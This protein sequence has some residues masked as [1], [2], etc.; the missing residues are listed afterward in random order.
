MEADGIN[1]F[2]SDYEQFD[3]EEGGDVVMSHLDLVGAEVKVKKAKSV[4]ERLGPSP[5]S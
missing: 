1:L 3:M 4:F 5:P 2:D